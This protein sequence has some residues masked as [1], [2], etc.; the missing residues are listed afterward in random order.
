MSPGPTWSVIVPA[1]DEARALPS[2]L[3]ALARQDLPHEVVVADGGSRDGTPGIAEGAGARVVRAAR[4]R[5]VQMNAGAR[6]ARG[7][8]LLFLHADVVPAG[9][10]LRRAG[11]ALDRPSVAAG[12]F[13]T[14]FD[15]THPL[16][17]G[18]RWKTH[19]WVRVLGFAPGDHGLFLDRR[20]FERVGGFPSVPVLE[21]RYI[22]RSL[23]RLGRIAVVRSPA[24]ASARRFHAEGVLRTYGRMAA[25]MLLDS[26]GAGPARLAEVYRGSPR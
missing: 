19:L 18:G 14:R 25:V 23:R 12:C 10:A 13:E 2:L 9:D 11:E 26:L 5:A 24:L 17:R 15:S 6:A 3:E 4:G 16:L 7:S 21:E 20:L 8:R 1:L 22:C